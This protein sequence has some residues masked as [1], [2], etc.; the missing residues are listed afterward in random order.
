MSV[1]EVEI[2]EAVKCLQWWVDFVQSTDGT[3]DQWRP[4]IWNRMR[5]WLERNEDCE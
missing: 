4:E 1:G 3:P 2:A 5:S